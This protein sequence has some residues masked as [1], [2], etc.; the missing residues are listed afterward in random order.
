M[1]LL[2]M[3]SRFLPILLGGDTNILVVGFLSL[4]AMMIMGVNS[5]WRGIRC[6]HGYGRLSHPMSLIVFAHEFKSVAI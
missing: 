3:V 6:H 4:K 2:E 1:L 5:S